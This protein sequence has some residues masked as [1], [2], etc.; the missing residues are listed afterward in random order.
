M[1]YYLGA[2]N[3]PLV[4]RGHSMKN[5][6]HFCL[7]CRRMDSCPVWFRTAPACTQKKTSRILWSWISLNPKPNWLI[8]I[9]K[10]YYYNSLILSD[11]VLSCFQSLEKKLEVHFFLFV[12]LL[13]SFTF[14][15]CTQPV[16]ESCHFLLK[17]S[18]S[19]L[20]FCL[21]IRSPS[22]SS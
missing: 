14:I 12:F 21:R 6:C 5:L 13:L 2:Y 7:T 16:S 19:D 1:K 8:F 20:R 9:P 10:D 11:L 4:S 22:A 18:L 15:S 17:I 3:Q